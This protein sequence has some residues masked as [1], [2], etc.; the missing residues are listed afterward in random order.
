MA[1]LEYS[2]PTEL[3][4]THSYFPWSF[5]SDAV[6]CSA[7]ARNR[8]RERGWKN[9]VN[10]HKSTWL[11]FRKRHTNV[12][13]T[14]QTLFVNNFF[15]FFF[16][17]RLGSKGRSTRNR[18]KNGAG[19]DGKGREQRQR[20]LR[21]FLRSTFSSPPSPRSSFTSIDFNP[22]IPFSETFSIP[23]FPTIV[24]TSMRPSFSQQTAT[25]QLERSS[26]MTRRTRGERASRARIRF[27]FFRLSFLFCSFSFSF[28]FSI[29][30][31]TK[32]AATRQW[33]LTKNTLRG[34][35]IDSA[36]FSSSRSL[37]VL[38]LDDF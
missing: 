34:W 12:T 30:R 27:R 6:I 2:V 29:L 26:R 11:F 10:A 17:P 20:E 31:C 37:R 3:F 14:F 19:R 24:D 23:F 36:C 8:E 18:E 28:F 7:P 25:L 4:A 21:C 15:F 1:D 13:P 22:L 33:Q 16:G 5:T 35:P 38:Q 32:F 9:A